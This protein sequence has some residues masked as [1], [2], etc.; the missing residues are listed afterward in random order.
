MPL[1]VVFAKRAEKQLEEIWD[2]TAHNW[3]AEQADRYISG[4][5]Q[6]L[7]DPVLLNH[8]YFT[9]EYKKKTYKYFIYQSHKLFFRLEGNTVYVPLILHKAMLSPKHI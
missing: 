8:V 2:Y 9:L 7:K 1:E 3:S 6:A 5:V 4:L